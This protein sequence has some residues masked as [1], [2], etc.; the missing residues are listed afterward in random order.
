MRSTGRPVGRGPVGRTRQREV[1]VQ[2]RNRAVGLLAMVALTAVACQSR[3]EEEATAE[4]AA[5]STLETPAQPAPAATL[6]DAEI[7]AVVVAANTID[8]QYGELA[9]QRATDSG[10]KQFA[11]TMI[12]DHTAVNKNAVELVTKLGVTPQENDV[13]RSL[14]QQA[15]ETRALLAS[16]SGAEFDRAYIANEVAYHKAVLDALD[17]V[18][19][20][21]AANA[22]LKQTLIDVRP[23][24]DGHLRHAESLSRALTGS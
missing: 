18:L 1:D 24:F 5:E 3:T 22:E 6:T 11:E 9:R 7:A 17:K 20:P 12:R 19:I 21:S 10:V 2:S 14:Q 16:K 13:S 23:A 15:T 8:V 4:A